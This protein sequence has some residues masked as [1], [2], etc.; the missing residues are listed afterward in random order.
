MHSGSRFGSSDRDVMGRAVAPLLLLIA[1]SATLLV[2][3]GTRVTGIPPLGTLLDPL[4]GLYR[5]ARLADSPAPERFEVPGLQS[6]VRIEW[7]DRGVP[8]IFAENDLDAVRV[9]G[10]VIAHDRLFQLDFLPRAASGRLAEALGP[11]AVPTDR[12]L[13]RTGMDWGAKKNLARING[14]AGEELAILEAYAEGI[15]AYLAGLKPRDL[16]LEF[17][18]LGY[19]PDPWTPLQT[20]RLLQY[21]NYDLSYG[22]D[23]PSYGWLRDRLGVADFDV[24]YPPFEGM[25]VPIVPADALPSTSSSMSTTADAGHSEQ[26]AA[27][28]H[29]VQ[30]EAAGT[31]VQL[32]AAAPRPLKP[33]APSATFL[34]RPLLEG[35][36]HGKGSNSW[37]V[38]PNRSETGHAILAGDMHLSVTLPPIWYEVHLVTPT[39][40]SYGVTIPGAPLPVE[41]FNNYLGWTFTNTGSDQIDHYA[42]ELDAART[43]YRYE[44]AWRDLD[45]VLDTIRIKGD[46]AVIDTLR[47]AHWGPVVEHAGRDVALQWT[48]H[49]PS[50]TLAALYAMNRAE[51]ERAFDRGLRMWDTPMQNILYASVEGTI[52]IRSTGFLPVRRAGPGDGLLDGSTA[53][54]EWI[55]RVPFDELPNASNPRQGFLTSTNQRPTDSTYAYYVGSDWRDQYRSLRID[56]LLRQKARHSVEDMT[57]YQSDVHAVQYD[58]FFPLIDTLS[59]LSP[60]ADH[61]R[62]ALRNWDGTMARD[63]GEPLILDIFLNELSR[64]AW[65]E[66]V[67][68]PIY[69]DARGDS[70]GA[71]VVVPKPAESRLFMLLRDRPSL[72]WF[73][74]VGTPGRED[75]AGLLREALEAAAHRL[76]AVTAGRVGST[77][78]SRAGTRPD[79]VPESMRWGRHRKIEFQHLIGGPALA[80]LG[81]GPFE[82]SG[83][84]ETLSPASDQ[85]SHHSA[86]WRVI[87]D[88][89][90]G[91]PRGRGIYP[92]G[93]RGNPFSRLYDL[94]LPAYLAV[95]YYDLFKPS[96]SGELGEARLR[97]ETF[98]HPAGEEN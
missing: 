18:L 90:S 65:D 11:A 93:Q 10:F 96:A 28:G 55:G 51:D 47:Y 49:K 56:S 85:I 86:S 9:L 23:D 91:E 71:A 72:S 40:N 70:L 64:L 98:V 38:A 16:P 46:D 59:R 74:V 31:S 62:A 36:V 75:A 41:A 54:F 6:A 89:S 35:F 81:R 19:Q 13:R 83:Y 63:R 22:T 20:L 8:H 4:D 17:R 92:G 84:R 95:E 2:M 69:V 24:L 21:M 67:F 45:V 3:L 48:A 27:A 88:F 15:N 7:D 34:S 66:P 42:I 1:V 97:S 94:H 79:D 82:Y 32:T 12:F 33:G 5:T 57:S 37:A 77:G 58:L 52:S 14:D 61:L 60:R 68:K 50:R 25:Y 76:E 30:P 39:M 73:D 44:G 26:L 80:A 87:V 53:A 29:S 43:R 78:A